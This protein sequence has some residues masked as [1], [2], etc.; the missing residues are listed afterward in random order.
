MSIFHQYSHRTLKYCSNALCHSSN[1]DQCGERQGLHQYSTVLPSHSQK[2]INSHLQKCSGKSQKPLTFQHFFQSPSHPLQPSHIPNASRHWL[3]IY[4]VLMSL[5]VFV[6]LAIFLS[7]FTCIY[8]MS[9]FFSRSTTLVATLMPCTPWNGLI[10][11]HS[12]D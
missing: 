12:V 9:T 1:Q 10:T 6:I 7:M 3:P 11:N 8:F 4:S 2:L 5:P